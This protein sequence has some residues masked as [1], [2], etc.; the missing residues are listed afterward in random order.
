MLNKLAMGTACV[1][2]VVATCYLTMCILD[3]RENA[4][5]RAVSMAWI[6]EQHARF[7]EYDIARRVD[8]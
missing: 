5:L 6:E 2:A 4:K 8:E 7:I 3:L 1:A